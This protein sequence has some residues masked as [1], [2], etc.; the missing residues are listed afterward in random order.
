M[1]LNRSAYMVLGM[2][3]TG[4]TTGYEISKAAELTSRFFWAAGDGQVYPQLRK[5]T[6]LG[7]IEREER[8][9]GERAKNV[10]SLTESGR[11]ALEEWLTST[12]R[13]MLELRDEGL[14]KL[15]FS[16]RLDT[17]QLCEQIEV[18]R[19]THQLA[20][21]RLREIEPM[22]RARAGT[23]LTQRHGLAIHS[24]AVTW[25]EQILAQLRDRD[26]RAS[27]AATLESIL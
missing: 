11:L 27:A 15:L 9:T 5:L 19:R 14:L 3:A 4:Y 1:R 16:E 21:D 24:A 13:P 8:A 12:E 20:L 26:P 25:C 10:Y 22:A 6:E 7:L 17:G 23:L 2:I 18:M